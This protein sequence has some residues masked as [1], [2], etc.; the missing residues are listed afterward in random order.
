MTLW[1]DPLE[2][3][4]SAVEHRKTHVEPDYEPAEERAYWSARAAAEEQECGTPALLDAQE[5]TR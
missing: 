5:P 4:K 3:H 1:P 2:A